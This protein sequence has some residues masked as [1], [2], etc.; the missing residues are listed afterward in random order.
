MT[1]TLIFALPVFLAACAAG[2]S[3]VWVNPGVQALQAEQDFLA[4]AAQARRDFPETYR[5]ATAPRVTLGGGICRDRFCVGTSTGPEV[6]DTDR[7]EPLRERSLTACM[8]SKGYRQATVPACPAGAPV[9]QL[10][11]QPFDTRGTCVANGR[12]AAPA[13]R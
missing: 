8:Q 3:A 1:R 11:S 7:N 10:Q 2:P 12:L 6:F 5:I 4:C 9:T 13:A